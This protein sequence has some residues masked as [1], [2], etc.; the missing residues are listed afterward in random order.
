[1]LYLASPA[2]DMCAGHNLRVD[3]GRTVI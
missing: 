1:V 3:G 2:S